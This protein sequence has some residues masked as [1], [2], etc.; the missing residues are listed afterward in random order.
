MDSDSDSADSGGEG[1]S[2]GLKKKMKYSQ[3]YKSD[4]EKEPRF[5]GWLIKSQKGKNFGFCK[6]CNKDINI[7][8]GKDSLIKHTQRKIHEQNVKSIKSQPSMTKF[9]TDTKRRQR[10]QDTKEAEIRLAAFVAEHNL[11]FTVMEHLPDL[12]KNICSDSEIA[13]G[14][15]SSRNKTTSIVKNVIGQ[16]EFLN[17]CEDLRQNKF[18]L[19]V[20]E[21]TDVS[22]TKHL[23]SVVRYR[24]N[25]VI[26]DKF[27]LYYL[28]QM[29]MQKLYI[30][31]L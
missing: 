24:K 5:T 26:K 10:A 17:V 31:L 22:T 29:L 8:S 14:L 3:S 4:W 13:R 20:D 25:N 12:I 11:P 16:E 27:L 2:Y 1:T 21:S 7:S 19:I 23:C 6:A 28:Y 18:S 15:A 30:T 9:V